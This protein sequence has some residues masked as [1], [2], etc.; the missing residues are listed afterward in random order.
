MLVDVV[1][2]ALV[3]LKTSVTVVCGLRYDEGPPRTSLGRPE[4]VALAGLVPND[5]PSY[6]GAMAS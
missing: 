5:L 2:R 4:N 6:V 3:R 1:P